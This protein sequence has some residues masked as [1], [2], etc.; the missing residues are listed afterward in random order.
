MQAAISP[1]NIFGRLQ[2]PASKSMMQRVCAAALLH[3]GKTIISNPGT[4]DDDKAALTII[5]DLGARVT[6]MPDNRIG[7]ISN[8]VYPSGNSIFCGESGLSAR[9]FIPI[10]ALS[11]KA[12]RVEG[13]GSLLQRPLDAYTDILPKLEVTVQHN[14]GRL[15]FVVQ[16][17]LQPKN[18]Q[19]DGSVSSQF[20][21]GLLFALSQQAKESITIG[22][23]NLKSTPYIDLTLEVLRHFGAN[24]HH[25]NYKVFI[26]EPATVQMPNEVSITIE[27]D[28]SSAAAIMTGAALSGSVSFSGLNMD[29]TQADKAIIEVLQMAGAHVAIEND[30]IQIAQAALQGFEFNATHCPD[31]FPVLAILASCSKGESRIHGVHR[32]LHKESNRIESICDMLEAF[33][34]FFAVEDDA[35]YIEGQRTLEQATVSSYDDHRIVMAAAIG[36]LRAYDTVY[37]SKA[38]AVSKSYPDFFTDLQKLGAHIRLNSDRL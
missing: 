30:T 7:I 19:L 22:V 37:I 11:N 35:L 10:A 32:L 24:V 14:S 17:P 27:N 5:Q 33:S 4:S 29:S 28:W 36:A 18:I 3:E 21:S 34:V 15:P 12:I 25:D 9:L 8:G 6:Y 2:V 38:E 23:S 31:L 16:G 13:T 1:G 26:I 20:L